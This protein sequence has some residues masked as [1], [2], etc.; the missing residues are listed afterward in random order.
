MDLA[1]NNL[2]WL[3]CHET[4]SSNRSNKHKKKRKR[5][6]SLPF[7]MPKFPTCKILQDSSCEAAL[8]TFQEL[9]ILNG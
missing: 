4:Q 2:Q 3:I 1:L 5:I 8:N 7:R 6:S 9:F